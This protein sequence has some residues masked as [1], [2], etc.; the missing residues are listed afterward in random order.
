MPYKVVYYDGATASTNPQT[1]HNPQTEILTV[2]AGKISLSANKAGSFVFSLNPNHPMYDSLSKRNGIIDV[3]QDADIIFSGYITDISTDFWTVRTFTVDGFF[4]QFNDTY[5]RPDTLSGSVSSVISTLLTN[6]N[7]Q[8]ALSSAYYEKL[9]IRP[10]II[11]SFGDYETEVNMT[12]TIK[13]LQAIQKQFGGFM[14][15]R[16]STADG[17]LYLDY[18]KE[19][20][21]HINSQ[22]VRI[23]NNIIS[24]TKKT[25]YEQVATYI[26][27]LGAKLESPAVKDER[28][29]LSETGADYIA[30]GLLESNYGKV[31]K[32][33]IFDDATTVEELREKA[34]AYIMDEFLPRV[35]IDAKAFDISISTSDVERF[36]LL[37][38]A[39]VIST[40]HDIDDY[41]PITK[42]SIDILDPKKNTIT[43]GK[44]TVQK[45]SAQV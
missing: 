39:E 7:D 42:M 15:V 3:Y 36:N 38:V 43:F 40:Y 34:E 22:K 27:P 30:T 29:R 20:S 44:E 32:T 37:D 11:N 28:L 19:E 23:G 33:V 1:I 16:R 31:F 17:Y 24:L 25:N 9:K 21:L 8:I 14:R 18:L 45:I 13:V 6:H 26:I 35:C 10:G 5:Q 12:P 41:F 2:D 4:A